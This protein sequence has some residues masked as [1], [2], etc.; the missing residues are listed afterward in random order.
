MIY[1]AVIVPRNIIRN[2]VDIELVEMVRDGGALGYKNLR[3]SRW[4]DRGEWRAWR[5]V[6]N[7]GFVGGCW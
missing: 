1:R 2:V 5:I 6:L 4:M 3:A 7:G